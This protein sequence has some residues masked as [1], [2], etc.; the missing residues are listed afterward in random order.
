MAENADSRD[1]ESRQEIERDQLRRLGTLIDCVYGVGLIM[2]VTWLPLPEESHLEGPIWIWSL[3][4]EFSGNLMSVLIGVV[5][6]ILYWLRN[7]SHLARLERSDSRH[8]SLS[9]LSVVFLLLLLYVVRVSSEVVGPSRRVGESFAVALVGITAAWAFAHA[10]KAGLLRPVVR[11]EE[12][13][14]VQ[15]EA[16]TEPLT[17]LLTMPLAFAGELAWNLGWLLYIPVAALLRRKIGPGDSN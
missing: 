7:A 14:G 1:V 17:A 8:A 6:L 2:V 11:S 13:V 10:R 12:A 5:F 9:I 4:S 3:F 16:W 15:I